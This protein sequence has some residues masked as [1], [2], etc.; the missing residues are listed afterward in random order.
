MEEWL[1]PWMDNITSVTALKELDL[2]Q[3]LRTYL[4]YARTRWLDTHLPVQ[5]TFP[6]GS[7]AVDYTQPVPVASARAQVFYGTTATPQ[8]ASGLVPLRLAL[9]SPAGRPQAITA[10]LEN[11]WQNGWL[12]MRRDMRGRYPKHEWPENPALAPAQPKAKRS[13]GR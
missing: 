7:A 2:S 11:F 4:G 12:D 6:G 1:A 8:L 10:D 3:L 5:L 13:S 9:L